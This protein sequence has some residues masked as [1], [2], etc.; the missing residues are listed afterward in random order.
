MSGDADSSTIQLCGDEDYV[1]LACD[2]FFDAVKPSVVPYLVLDA[3]QQS[4]EPEEVSSQ[5]EEK[6]GL[7]VAQQLVSH[8][9]AAGSSD[10]IT[11]MLVFL[12]QLEQLLPQDLT[13]GTAKTSQ[14]STSQN[15]PQ[16]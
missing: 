8:A 4:G 2:G 1:L 10:N 16:Q 3:L 6:P 13:T 12:R 11:V 14:E 9:K 15:V 7:R 5:F